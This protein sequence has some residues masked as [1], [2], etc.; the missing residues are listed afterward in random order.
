M[1]LKQNSLS[2]IIALP[3]VKRE[4]SEILKLVNIALTSNID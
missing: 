2:E 4:P 1:G 3:T